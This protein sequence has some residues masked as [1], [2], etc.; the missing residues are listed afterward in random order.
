MNRLRSV[1]K[2]LVLEAAINP[3]GEQQIK[4]LEDKG[5]EAT[6]SK[7]N[8]AEITLTHKKHKNHH[9][10]IYT[11]GY[12]PYPIYGF[13]GPMCFHVTHDPDEAHE[14][15]ERDDDHDA[16]DVPASTPVRSSLVPATPVSP[17]AAPSASAIG[18]SSSPP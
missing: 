14:A 12:G 7:D 2:R 9:L 13:A 15:V 1:A 10:K 11:Y 6:Q 5:W 3:Q 16:D 8:K 4:R 18:G 17:A